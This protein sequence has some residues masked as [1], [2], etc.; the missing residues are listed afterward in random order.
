MFFSCS[1]PFFDWHKS[2]IKNVDMSASC[3]NEELLPDRDKDYNGGK[4][5]IFS[6]LLAQCKVSP[7]WQSYFLPS[8]TARP[9]SKHF[10]KASSSTSYSFRSHNKELIRSRRLQPRLDPPRPQ[11][12]ERRT[13]FLFCHP[14]F[15]LLSLTP[16]AAAAA[17]SLPPSLVLIDR[18]PQLFN[19]PP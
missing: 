1:W 11:E 6:Y 16:E 9:Q 15:S 13:A 7:Q 5:N 19:S 12:R 10:F 3:S 2:L 14:R 4:S 18:F 17:F 8:L